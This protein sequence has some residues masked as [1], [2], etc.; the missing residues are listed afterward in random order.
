[1]YWYWVKVEVKI[2]DMFF[3]SFITF[4]EKLSTEL[5]W[6]GLRV[7]QDWNFK[8]IYSLDTIL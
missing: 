3:E 5:I 7:V 2:A 4:F 6:V 1:M 8:S